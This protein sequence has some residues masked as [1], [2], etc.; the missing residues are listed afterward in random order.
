MKRPIGTLRI[1]LADDERDTREFFKALLPRLGHQVVGTAETG[2]KLV[3]LCQTAQPDL[4][5]VDIKMP[6]M[7]GFE[8]AEKINQQRQ[9]P[10]IV[11][12][13]HHDAEL[14]VR[15]GVDHIMAY[16]L[17]PVKEP[18]VES[19]IYLAILRFEHFQRLAK[20]ADTLREALES[21]KVIERAKGIIM[22][23]AR[24]DEDDAFRRLQ[25]M[26]SD[27]NRKLI[28][29]AQIIMTAEEAFR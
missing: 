19:A 3:E 16:L 9:V 14:L 6:D 21:R 22:K 11:V 17:K 27:R 24:V 28:D 13:A 7:D 2:R 23:R 18:D 15:A 20:E 29:M 10:V 8:A 26:A 5:I 4:I 1:A 12:S 25:K